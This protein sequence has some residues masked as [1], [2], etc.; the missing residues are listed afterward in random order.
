VKQSHNR[1]S[2][3]QGV[4][5]G[6]GSQISWHSTHE[7]GEVVNLTHRPPLPPGMFI[8]LIF[9]R[10]WVNPRAMVES[11]GNMS[12]KNPMTPP[13]IDPRTI[14]LVVQSLICITCNVQS[15]VCC[16]HNQHSIRR[17]RWSYNWIFRLRLLM[18]TILSGNLYTYRH[19]TGR[20]R[21][22]MNKT[23]IKQLNI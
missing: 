15:S 10:G 16:A 13:G 5:G 7:G 19:C 18:R 22:V 11:E 2:V 3:A 6:L 23:L 20:P 14:Q 21:I 8:V 12:L 17:K 1:S 4:P 9:T